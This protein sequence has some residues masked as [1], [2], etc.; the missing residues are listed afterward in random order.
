MWVLKHPGTDR[1][2]ELRAFEITQGLLKIEFEIEF[3]T[4]EVTYK[5]LCRTNLLIVKGNTTTVLE[6]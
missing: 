5:A 6:N 1:Y 3:V 4:A 2:N